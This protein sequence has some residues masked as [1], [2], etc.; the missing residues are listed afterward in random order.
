MSVEAIIKEHIRRLGPITVAEYMS[1]AL[2]HPE[3]GYYMRLDPLGEAGDFIT[4]PEISQ[5]FGELI[6]AWLAEQWIIMGKPQAALIELGPG[7]GTLMN[8]V[9]RA[10][11]SVAGFHEAMSL[12]L[13]EASPIL[14]QKQRG[15]LAGKHPNLQWHT[16][17]DDIPQKPLL[18]IANEFFDALPIRQF[19]HNENKWQERMVG[20]DNDCLTFICHPCESR[21]PVVDN[22]DASRRWHDNIIYEHSQPS[23]DITSSIA[24]HIVAHDGAALMID[25]GYAGGSRGDTLQAVR[26][27][28][29]HDTLTEPGMADLTAHVDFDALK[30]AA[31]AVGAAAH[32]AVTQRDFLM[33]L[34]GELRLARLSK[35]ATPAQKSAMLSAWKRLISEDQMGDLFKA[36]CVTHP[37]HPKPEAF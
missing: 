29:Y 3:H 12:H 31:L 1:L 4:A 15:L 2:L 16:S 11:K 13:V 7:R 25:Y 30:Q 18:L 34:G 22:L 24:R 35:N 6:G 8:D 19:I 23:L 37:K 9:L 17:F 10:T 33:R 5:I 36:L 28:R 14:Q 27:H 20:I 21:D 26:H 32:G